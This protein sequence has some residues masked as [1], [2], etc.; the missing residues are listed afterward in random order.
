ML[1]SSIRLRRWVSAAL[2]AAILAFAIAAGAQEAPGCGEYV[3]RLVEGGHN[4]KRRECALVRSGEC[5]T[6]MGRFFRPAVCAADLSETER[7]RRV[8]VG[9]PSL[10]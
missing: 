5:R 2:A 7:W 10:E 1:L 6:L 3:S 8:A 4:V 9:F